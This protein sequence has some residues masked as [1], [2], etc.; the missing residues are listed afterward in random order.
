[1]NTRGVVETISAR[2]IIC[3]VLSEKN[4]P[5]DDLKEI[6]IK[7]DAK[8]ILYVKWFN[9]K[10]K[11]YVTFI[12]FLDVHGNYLLQSSEYKF[13]ARKKTHNTWNSRKFNKIIVPEG[14]VNIRIILEHE[15]EIK[16]TLEY[17]ITVQ[18]IIAL[19]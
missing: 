6:N 5:L 4:V 13:K 8:V 18:A 7:E 19:F 2:L 16:Y 10:N 3:S 9:L 14:I 11:S 17:C 15:I 1:M 12:V